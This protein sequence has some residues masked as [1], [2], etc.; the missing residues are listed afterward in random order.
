[1]NSK[2]ILIVP[3]IFITAKS[4][5]Q[6]YSNSLDKV[7]ADWKENVFKLSYDY[8][9]VLPTEKNQ[10][11]LK[12]DFKTQ[13]KDY[14]NSVLQYFIDGNEDANW[15]VQ[16]NRIRKWYHA[17]SMSWQPN[18]RPYG[19]EFI[20][21]LTR[22][23]NSFPNELYPT[24][25]SVIQNWAVGFYN[26]IGAYTFGQVWADTNNLKINNIAFNEGTVAA[27]LL[28]TAADQ[29][30]VPYIKGSLEWQANIHTAISGTTDRKPQTVRL[31]QVDIA[32][33]DSRANDH[34]GWVFGTFAYNAIAKGNKIWDKLVPVGLTWG[35]DPGNFNGGK[36]TETWIN[37]VFVSLFKFPNGQLMHLGYKGRLNGPVDNPIS[38]CL[39]CH[40]TA[41]SPQYR[42]LVPDVTKPADLTI[43]FRNVKSNEAFDG[44]S[45]SFTMDYSLQLAGGVA[46]FLA[47]RSQMTASNLTENKEPSKAEMK[48]T[49]YFNTSMDDD[50]VLQIKPD[51]LTG[52]TDSEKEIK[53]SERLNKLIYWI[54]GVFILV[55]VILFINNKIRK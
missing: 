54:I 34:T 43:Y 15:V 10:P 8:P 45:T 7:P 4:I 28:F 53:L 29:N 42:P 3:L 38:S 37:P 1:M 55:T 21:G 51:N 32:V 17:P 41:Q 39:S 9:K 5:S 30:Q 36:L 48:L 52:K 24:Q 33:K 11:W 23:R 46:A 19:R 27:K 12:Y 47:N 16:N 49:E 25:T 40:S 44:L 20:H 31:L 18:N 6:I 14:M 50:I 2:I 22:E 26:P 35:N 13:P